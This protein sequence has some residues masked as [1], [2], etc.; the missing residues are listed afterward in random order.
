MLSDEEKVTELVRQMY[1]KGQNADWR[2]G[3]EDLRSQRRPRRVPVPD[4]K[5]LAV[6]AVAAAALIVVGLVLANGATSHKSVAGAPTT[7]APPSI[8]PPTTTSTRP[9]SVV[10]PNVIGETQ[11]QASATMNSAGLPVGGITTATNGQVAAGLVI[12]ENP[13]PG[14]SIPPGASVTLVISTGP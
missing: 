2:L 13:A 6:L 12:S 7:T 14:S 11:A 5:L 4:T 9:A 8:L 10:V 3:P 1:A